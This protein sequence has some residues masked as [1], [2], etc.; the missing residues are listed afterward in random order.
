MPDVPDSN[1]MTLIVAPDIVPETSYSSS[2]EDDFYDADED[3]A[4]PA[5]QNAQKFITLGWV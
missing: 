4:T 3:I 1:A 2:D 5:S